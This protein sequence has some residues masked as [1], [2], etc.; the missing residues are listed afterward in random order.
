MSCCHTAHSITMNGYTDPRPGALSSDC[1]KRRLQDVGRIGIGAWSCGGR[2]AHVRRQCWSLCAVLQQ[3]KAD[4]KRRRCGVLAGTTQRRLRSTSSNTSW[5]AVSTAR[6]RQ[7]H[8][9]FTS[10]PVRSP[11]AFLPFKT[12]PS[13]TSLPARPNSRRR[14]HRVSRYHRSP[15]IS[16]RSWGCNSV[17]AGGYSPSS[18]NVIRTSPVASETCCLPLLRKLMG[19]A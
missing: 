11:Y 13:I 17:G 19:L 7:P 1:V 15:Y 3:P 6:P 8:N 18:E 12:P 4:R 10:R 14:P 16:G 9:S 2:G 5:K